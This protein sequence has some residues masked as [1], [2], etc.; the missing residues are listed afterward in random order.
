MDM[1][2]T[3]ILVSVSLNVR[4]LGKALYILVSE[5]APRFDWYNRGFVLVNK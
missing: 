3:G 1:A 2:L 4:L 5:L